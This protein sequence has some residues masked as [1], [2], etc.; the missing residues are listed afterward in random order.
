LGKEEE[1]AHPDEF[2][3]EGD[4]G[5]ERGASEAREG[6]L[7]EGRRRSEHG[8]KIGVAEII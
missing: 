7:R 4:E 3:A 2:V 8:R 1:G 5:V 6:E